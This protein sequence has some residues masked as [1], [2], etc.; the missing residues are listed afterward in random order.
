MSSTDGTSQRPGPTVAELLNQRRGDMKGVALLLTWSG[1][2]NGE[3]TAVRIRDVNTSVVMR[4]DP[5]LWLHLADDASSIALIQQ[6][7]ATPGNSAV[8]SE[9]GAALTLHDD[10][11]LVLQAATRVLD[12]ERDEDVRAETMAWLGG[13]TGD[14]RVVALLQRA[15]EDSS[16]RVRDEA[17]TALGDGRGGQPVLLDL[18]RTSKHA[19]VR[20]EAVQ[21]LSGGGENVVSL[22]LRVAFDDAEPDVQAEAVDAIK[23]RSGSAAT[24][25][26][27]EIAQRH[28]DRRLRSEARDAL[29]ERGFR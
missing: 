26:L 6:I 13:Q 11:A 7:M 17:L 28:P 9:L 27:R 19:D 2:T 18:I 1:G 23:E 5:L 16:P 21:K 3:L 25:A 14:A 12:T 10:R 4:S 8:R 22:L 29:D 20:G 24:R 15:V